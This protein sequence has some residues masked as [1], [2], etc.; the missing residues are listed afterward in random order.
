[1]KFY[2]LKDGSTV[3]TVKEA[4]DISQRIDVAGLFRD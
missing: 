1:M 4:T 2:K 3:L